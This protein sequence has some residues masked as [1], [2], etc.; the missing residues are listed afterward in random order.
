MDYNYNKVATFV[1]LA[2]VLSLVFGSAMRSWT[3]LYDNVYAQSQ[4]PTTTT[5]PP[6]I[7]AIV[8]DDLGFS[9]IGSFGSEISTPNLDQLAK[10]GKILTN[11]HTNS[12]CSPARVSFLT[13]VDNH[14]GGLGTMYENIAPNQEGKPG[15]ETYINNRVVT[16]EEQLRDSGYNTLMSGKWHLSGSGW[17]N[18][19]TPYDRGFEDVFVLLESGAQHFNGDPYYAGGH[20]TFLNNNTQVPRPDNGTYSNDI[21]TNIMLDKIKNHQA[22]GKPLF[23]YLSFQ[24]SHSPFQAPQESMKK[25][26]G[27]YD[28]GYDK[29][30]EQRFEKQKQLGIWP[31]NMTL[32]QRL[33]QTPAWDSL[34]ATDK[35]YKAKVLEAHAGMIDNMDSNIGKVIQYLKDTGQYE[36]TLILF[37]SDNGSSEPVEMKNLGSGE[38]E[39][40]NKFFNSFN[41]SLANVGNA[42]SLVNYGAWGTGAAVSPFS[43]F[44]T[45]QGEGGVRAPLVMKLP[46]ASNQTQPDIVDAFVHVNDITPTFLDYAG[47]QPSGPT[48]N[49]NPVHPIM[50][51]S[52]KPLLE[53]E[54]EQVYADDEP[55]AQE[56]FNNTAVWK[57]DWKAVRN[58]QPLGDGQ[59][60]LFNYTADIGENND[61]ASQNPE[62][63]K[64]LISDYNKFAK[65]VGVIVPTAIVEAFQTIG[66]E[67]D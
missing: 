53:G 10:E 8:G 43:Y 21:Y 15:Y 30:R 9:D 19:S 3:P 64:V 36:N 55:V 50:G 56:M 59:W 41:N 6:N 32:P 65:D 67:A 11:Y 54:V 58:M 52:L 39:E 20:S 22:G 42:D 31:Q 47:V 14:I 28:V 33:P 60:H 25:Y 45:T 17:Q 57:G 62:I 23:M 12:V 18:G 7:L 29:I 37:T 26:E 63:L 16:V 40:A 24:A 46:G 66:Q 1:V 13:G 48:Y 5:K 51:K 4:S 38:V 44:K 2:T 27:V 49:G 61:L 35:A 34:N